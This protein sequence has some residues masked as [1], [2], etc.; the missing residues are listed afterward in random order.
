M[1]HLWYEYLRFHK[2]ASGH[3]INSAISSF[4]AINWTIYCLEI[5]SVREYLNYIE[6]WSN[7]EAFSVRDTFEHF[8]YLKKFSRTSLLISDPF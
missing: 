8:I 6:F 5:P 3:W 4:D 2:I 7:I 1:Y